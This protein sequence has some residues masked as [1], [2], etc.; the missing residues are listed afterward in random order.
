MPWRWTARTYSMQSDNEADALLPLSA[1][2]L[3][4]VPVFQLVHAIHDEITARVDTTL[5]WDQLRSPQINQFLVRPALEK[6]RRQ[7]HSLAIPYALLANQAQYVRESSEI[8]AQAGVADTRGLL[9]ELLAIKCL[10]EYTRQELISALTY[11]FQPLA[12]STILRRASAPRISTLE[13]AI[14]ACS[15]NFLSHPLVVSILSGIWEGSITFHSRADDLHRGQS[16]QRSSYL[17]RE[18]VIYN[19][20]HASPGKLSRLRVPRYR[21]IANTFAL[22]ALL[23]LYL[24]VLVERSPALT[25]LEIV[26]WFWSLGFMLDEVMNAFDAGYS[27]YVMSLWNIFDC[28]ILLL[29]IIYCSLRIYT[30]LSK[31]QAVFSI[32][33]DILA[34]VA[35]LLFPRLF[36]VLDH[37]PYFSQ[38]LIS[39]RRMAID[40]CVS[41]LFI[42]IFFV[43]FWVAFTLSFA[44]DV[45]DA[46]TI[47]YQL[48]QIFLGFTVPAWN[49]W[50][51]Y[52]ALGKT[53]LVTF[54]FLAHF[55][56]VT[57]FVT[58]LSNSF[59]DISK[60]ARQEHLY[61]FAVNTVTMVKSDTLFAY[62]APFN[63]L[64]WAFAPLVYVLPFRTFVHFNRTI[65]KV[66][67]FPVLALIYAYEH[68]FLRT[69][70]AHLQKEDGKGSSRPKPR[71]VSRLL[72]RRDSI[73]SRRTGSVLDQVFKSSPPAKPRRID[74]NGDVNGSVIHADGVHDWVTSQ[75]HSM[76]PPPSS[77]R[78]GQKQRSIDELEEEDYESDETETAR[79]YDSPRFLRDR[80]SFDTL[81]QAKSPSSYRRVKS[82]RV[83]AMDTGRP[84]LPHRHSVPQR[85]PSRPRKY[86]SS[87]D[88][89]ND[90][91]M[92]TS[93]ATQLAAMSRHHERKQ[94]EDHG[95]LL[96]ARLDSIEQVVKERLDQLSRE[97]AKLQHN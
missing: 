75:P 8:P 55:I 29:L 31:T 10:K 62:I 61:L 46:S 13:V 84:P 71:G 28:G 53:L 67:H 95:A 86:R 68:F 56:I 81:H 38:M 58:I 6:F 89:R 91:V 27:L 30:I 26:F 77:L 48:M 45:Y 73:T 36:S 32:S 15:K 5:T 33:C 2:A 23:V 92:A 14:S 66:S 83:G 79:G 78:M 54:I 70:E 63:L 1:S 37:Y 40:M 64:E 42:M 97:M 18:A 12:G 51:N 94:D 59:A 76:S 35:V 3:D 82:S 41:M 44:R 93:L 21:N 25:P 60:N 19:P 90:A 50:D 16:T 96:L 88:T 39:L 7:R 24:C 9:C 4:R 52:N 72:T 57:I 69:D 74:T 65:I 49:A 34:S 87:E 85:I 20:A 22:G 80:T 17:G 11:E 43:G 47:A